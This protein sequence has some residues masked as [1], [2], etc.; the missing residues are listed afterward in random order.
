MI[1]R[2][3]A[4]LI[5]LLLAYAGLQL[6][7]RAVTHHAHGPKIAVYR[8]PPI[9]AAGPLVPGGRPV[10]PVIA[11]NSTPPAAAAPGGTC[12]PAPAPAFTEAAAQ[13]SASLRAAAWSAFGRP[14]IGWEIYAPLAAHEL[15]TACAPTQSGFAQALA[16]WQGQHG[17]PGAG[18]MD[19]ATLKALNIVWLRRRPFVAATAH[20]ACPPPPDAFRLAFATP[21]EGY[22]TK[23][24][25]LRTTALAAYRRMAAAARQEVPSLSADKQLLTIFSGYRDPAEEAARCAAGGCGTVAKASCSA[26]RT[27]LALDLFLGAAPGFA[28]GSSA[29]ANRLFQA[30]SELY[31]WLVANAGSFG[32]VPYPF[33]PWHWEWT[34]EAP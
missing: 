21:G 17:L 9:L 32:F 34:G 24:I 10:A 2:L 18:V 31:R 28:P 7:W 1:W 4:V 11:P 23:P 15:A 8:P 13:N 5:G 20:G 6:A 22:L 19:E 14:E 16:L 29:D 25:Q 27:G 30:R 26:H 12:A 33:E 3:T